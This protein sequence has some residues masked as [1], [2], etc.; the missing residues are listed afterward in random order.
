LLGHRNT[1][2]P[3][4]LDPQAKALL[5]QLASLDGPKLEDLSPAEA[6]EVFKAFGAMFPVPEVA[7]TQAFKVPVD[8]GEIDAHVFWPMGGSETEPLPVLVWFHGGGWT[9]GDLSSSD[10]T[11]AELANASGCVVVNVDYRLAPEHPFP[12]PLEDCYAAVQWVVDRSGDLAVEP[13][14][15]AVGGDSAGGNLAAAVC[16]TARELG[17]PDIRFQLLVYPAVDA[18]MSYPSFRENAEGYFLTASTM[19]WFWRNYVGSADPE[20]P[21]LSPLYAKELAGLPPAL[22][23]TAE[24]DP[25]RD[26][27]EAYAERLRQAGVLAHASQYDGMIHGFLALTSVFDAGAKA[28]DEAAR[29]LRAAL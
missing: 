2:A 25:L 16:L 11:A 22:V 29:A 13:R 23:I 10:A 12:I 1:I 15:L 4:P 20:E 27:G 19:E 26:E 5:D 14:R 8:G 6:R 9:V 3:M 18:R 24:F 28:M 17:G 21:M 7:R